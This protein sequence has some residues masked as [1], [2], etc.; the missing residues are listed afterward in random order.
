MAHYDVTCINKRGDHYSP[1]ERIQA[2]GG[3]GWK[4]LENDAIARIDR[5]S[6]D[7]TVSRAGRT[8]RLV[9]ATHQGRRYLRTEPDGVSPDNLLALPE[10]P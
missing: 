1:H 10:C 9:V 7:Y 3:A 5:G 6:D 8:V 2:I 4:H